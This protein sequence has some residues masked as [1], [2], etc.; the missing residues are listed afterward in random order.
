MRYTGLSAFILLFLIG[1]RKEVTTKLAVEYQAVEKVEW[2][3]DCTVVL[4]VDRFGLQ[5]VGRK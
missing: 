5:M 3:R 1:A 4:V 2:S